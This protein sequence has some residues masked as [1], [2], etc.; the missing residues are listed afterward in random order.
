M[1]AEPMSGRFV[2]WERR[3]STRRFAAPDAGVSIPFGGSRNSVVDIG[4]RTL[5]RIFFTPADWAQRMAGRSSGTGAMSDVA[6]SVLADPAHELTFDVVVRD[7]RSESRHRV[8]MQADDAAR[9]AKPGAEPRHCVEAA[10]QFLL[11]REPKESI[12]GVFDMRIIRRYFPEFDDAFPGYLARLGG[13]PG[14]A[15]NPR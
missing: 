3:R 10:M 13:A 14:E 5:N 7:A 15:H 2:P 12:L 8:T 1:S 11:D 4:E 9:W 6:I